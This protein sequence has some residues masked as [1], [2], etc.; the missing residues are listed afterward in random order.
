M[1]IEV[2]PYFG[3]EDPASRARKGGDLAK[4]RAKWVLFFL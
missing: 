2:E 4:T 3:P 1:I